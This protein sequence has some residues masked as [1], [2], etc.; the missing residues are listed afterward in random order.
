MLFIR[1]FLLIAVVAGC[2]PST[3]L[4][5]LKLKRT[6]TSE[7]WSIYDR[8]P[9]SLSGLRAEVELISRGQ[10]SYISSYIGEK[11]RLMVGT[12]TYTRGLQRQKILAIDL[13]CSDF[14]TEME[15]QTFFLSNG[16]SSVDRHDLDRDGDGFA[17]DWGVQ[18]QQ[19]A[20]NVLKTRAEQRTQKKAPS[21]RQ[22]SSRTCHTGPRGGRYYY[23][24][25]GRKVYNC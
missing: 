22:S 13:D 1:F 18:I 20:R 11:T 9:L 19:I 6:P 3:E 8:D 21:Y 17:C 15:A 12:P 4:S 5:K 7:L 23:A 2:A 25:S 24:S 10:H 16:G 14:G